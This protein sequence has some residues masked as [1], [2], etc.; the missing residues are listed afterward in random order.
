MRFSKRLGLILGVDS[1]IEVSRRIPAVHVEIVQKDFQIANL[2]LI[3]DRPN[4]L[5]GHQVGEAISNFKKT[6]KSKY[7][8]M[9]TFQPEYSLL[10][11]SKDM[12]KNDNMS[13]AKSVS[14]YETT[15]VDLG[16][17]AFLIAGSEEI[18]LQGHPVVYIATPKFTPELSVE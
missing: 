11:I 1:Q 9:N 16:C 4:Q 6:N 12:N 5:N 8:D 10:H 14:P 15:L 17:Q 2:F 3:S 13:L 18:D 7:F